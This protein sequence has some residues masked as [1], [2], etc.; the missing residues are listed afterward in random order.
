MRLFLRQKNCWTLCTPSLYKNLP[1]RLPWSKPLACISKISMR[2]SRVFFTWRRP[3]VSWYPP[4]KQ[5]G[6]QDTTGL[7]QVKK[8]R[9]RRIEILEMHAKGFDHGSRGGRFL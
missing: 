4:W 9:E 6:Y 8:T 7:R 1:P 3:V 2:R 5:G